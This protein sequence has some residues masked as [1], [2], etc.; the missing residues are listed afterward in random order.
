VLLSA[1]VA[2]RVASGKDR[3]TWILAAGS[4][5]MFGMLMLS[6]NAVYDPVFLTGEV[7]DALESP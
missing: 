7:E 3:A 6:V 5:M 2:T 4:V 1:G